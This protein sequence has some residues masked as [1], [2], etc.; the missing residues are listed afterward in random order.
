MDYEDFEIPES[1]ESFMEKF[2][3]VFSRIPEDREIDR[4]RMEIFHK[5]AYG[6]AFLF[7][8]TA[9]IKLHPKF[10]AGGVTVEVPSIKLNPE[11]GKY[12][13]D[14]IAESSAFEIVPL[15]NGNIR[16]GVTVQHIYK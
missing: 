5:V 2:S 14:I 9:Q 15:L 8:T 4:E 16:I 11:T 3:E 1:L 10:A 6:L 12:L 13:S 7:R